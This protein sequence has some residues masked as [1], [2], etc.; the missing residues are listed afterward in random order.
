MQGGSAHRGLGPAATGASARSRHNAA[1]GLNARSPVAGAAPSARLP[2]YCTLLPSPCSPHPALRPTTT[3]AAPPAYS[4]PPEQARAAQGAS[5][6]Q[7]SLPCLK[8][9]D[10]SQADKMKLIPPFPP[11]LSFFLFFVQRKGGFCL[12]ASPANHLRSYTLIPADRPSRGITRNLGTKPPLPSF[13]DNFRAPSIL[14][15]RMN[16]LLKTMPAQLKWLLCHL[17]P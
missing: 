5:S 7:P 10:Q 11:F 13:I 3:G 1:E 8:G 17:P 4:G 15:Q 9:K 2:A 6:P 14:M 16:N 12:G